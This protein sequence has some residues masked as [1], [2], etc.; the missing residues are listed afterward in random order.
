MKRITSFFSTEVSVTRKARTISEEIKTST[1]DP[2]TCVHECSDNNDWPSCWTVEQKTEFCYKNEWQWFQDKKL[3]CTVCRNVGSLSVEA[4]MGMKI[5]TEWS[6][7]E[8]TC[9]GDDRK[10]QLTSLRK[11]FVDSVNTLWKRHIQKHCFCLFVLYTISISSS[12]CERGFS[13]MN[14][15]IPPI[16]ASLM[17]K[18]VSSLIFIRLVGPPLTFFDPSKYVDWWLLRGRHSAV[19]SQSRKRNRDDLSDENMRKLWNLL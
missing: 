14:L 19:D 6:N 1:T 4:K 16:R 2:S 5:S 11:K 15:I 9:Y 10:K 18:T 8:I 3:G 7:G 17:T 13:Q 12:E